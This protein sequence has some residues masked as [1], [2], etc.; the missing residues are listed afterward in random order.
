MGLEVHVS[1]PS[2]RA[3]QARGQR[4]M[5][6]AS[7]LGAFDAR[8]QASYRR[9]L[10]GSLVEVRKWCRSSSFCNVGCRADGV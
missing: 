6:S 7:S 2:K 5:P 10:R 9:L 4:G 3:L 8:A 1:P